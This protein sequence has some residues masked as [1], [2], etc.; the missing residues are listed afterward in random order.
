MSP[1]MG[2]PHKEI[3]TKKGRNRNVWYLLGIITTALIKGKRHP[4]KE[5]KPFGMQYFICFGNKVTFIATAAFPLF[6]KKGL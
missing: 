3:L 1:L 2:G 6:G 4:S 5:T